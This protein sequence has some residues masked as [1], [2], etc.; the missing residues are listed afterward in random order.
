MLAVT[1]RIWS[2]LETFR[3]SLVQ[4]DVSVRHNY[5]ATYV[6]PVVGWRGGIIGCRGDGSSNG[7]D[8]QTTPLRRPPCSLVLLVLLLILINDSLSIKKKVALWGFSTLR[9]FGQFI[10][11]PNKFPHSSPEAPRIIQ[12]HEI[13]TREGGNYYQ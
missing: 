6:Q 11:T 10:L 4:S 8:W 12:I 9:P 2:I 13:A 5:T 7:A 3:Y 1:A